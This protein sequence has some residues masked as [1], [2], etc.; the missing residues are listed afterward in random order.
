M[1]VHIHMY[2]HLSSCLLMK[3]TPSLDSAALTLVNFILFTHVDNSFI[4][5]QY[6]TSQCILFTDVGSSLI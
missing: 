6:N 3:E 5:Q 2:V 1:L 4:W